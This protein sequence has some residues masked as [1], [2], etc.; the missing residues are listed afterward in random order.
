MTITSK[1]LWLSGV[2]SR[3][4]ILRLGTACAFGLPRA[5]SA[6]S[7]SNWSSRAAG[8]ELEAKPAPVEPTTIREFLAARIP[9][10]QGVEIFLDPSQ[11]NWAQFDPEL[12]YTLRDNVIKDG[13]DGSRSITSYE[14]TGERTKVNYA[15][16]PCRISAYGDSFTLSQQVSDGETWEEVLAAHLGEPIRNFGIGGYGTYQAYRRML[17]QEASSSASKYLI[18]NVWDLDDYLRSIDSWRWL[19]MGQREL[20][21]PYHGH[22]YTFHGNPWVH[23]RLDLNTGAL[24]ERPNLFATKDSLYQLADLDFVYRHFKDDLVVQLLAAREGAT[25]VDRDM[26]EKVAK[27]LGVNADISSVEATSQTA[28]A[29]HIEYGLRVGTKV[30]EKARDFA[31]DQGKQ[32]LILLSFGRTAVAHA[33]A[34]RPRFDQSVLDFLKK[35]NLLFVD[36]LEKHQADFKMFNLSPDEYVK[37]YYVGH[38]NPRGNLF[39]AFA[40]KDAVVNWLDPKPVAYR[41][42]SET[43]PAVS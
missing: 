38:Y 11:P 25:D 15:H 3:R 18:L 39:F 8:T 13:V 10:R 33:C 36:T 20:S 26:L 7:Q 21:R 29:I 43:I 14:K 34:G 6:H 32:L 24:V 35:E 37:L 9:T 1:S 41:Q 16:K 2:L 40:I 12:G 22:R 28:Q 4:N 5:A 19:R 23:A 31:R 42:G 27:A 17:R 30:I